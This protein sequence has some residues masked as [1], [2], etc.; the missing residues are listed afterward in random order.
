[1][2]A[3]RLRI[4]V[5]AFAVAIGVL[6]AAMLAFAASQKGAALVMGGLCLAG[7]IAGRLAG[8]SGPA[9]LAVAVGLLGSLW[10]IVG[11][12]P[13]GPRETSAA[14]HVVGGTV[15][16]WAIA[17]TLRGRGVRA[18][19]LVTMIALLVLTLA[20][21]AAELISEITVDTSLDLSVSDSTL[22]V[23]FGCFGGLVGVA[24]AALLAPP[25]RRGE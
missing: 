19:A 3:D 8:V 9:L 10:L 20:W 22:D 15:I 2:H 11:D 13:I 7:L 6:A 18:W 12:A 21:E 23:A 5:L 17:T 4:D 1:M 16:G 24:S 25:E 14:A